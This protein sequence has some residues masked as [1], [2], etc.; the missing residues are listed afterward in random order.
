MQLT[1]GGIIVVG[2]MI[3]LVIAVAADW[4]NSTFVAIVFAGIF[5]ISVIAN[6]NRVVNKK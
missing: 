5:I 4:I 1:I 2:F 3:F 6:I